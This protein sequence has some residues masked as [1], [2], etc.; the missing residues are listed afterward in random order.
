M[1]FIYSLYY[2][3]ILDIMA[4]IS[5]FFYTCCIPSISVHILVI[6]PAT[7]TYYSEARDDVEFIN[8]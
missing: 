2:S 6:S 7:Q 1:F 4:Y 8:K 5:L 3:L